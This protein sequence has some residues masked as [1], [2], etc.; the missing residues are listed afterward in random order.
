MYTMH[1]PDGPRTLVQVA[2]AGLLLSI[3]S[4]PAVAQQ[5]AVPI[6]V[7]SAPVATTMEPIHFPAEVQ[8]LAG[9]RL[10]VNAT[11]D[12]RLLVFDRSLKTATVLADTNG[13]VAVYPRFSRLI[14]YLGD[15][16]L[17]F[18]AATR[19]LILVGEEG[20]LG[21]VIALPKAQDANN[22]TNNMPV[23]VD[24][25]GRLIYAGRRPFRFP[26]SCRVIDGRATRDSLPAP[27][28][29]SVTI[30][31]ADFDTRSVDTIGRARVSVSGVTFP[32]MVTDANCRVIS[33]K[34]RID[35]SVPEVDSWTV[36]STGQV[37]IVRGHDYHVD[38]IDAS[39]TQRSTPKL[40]FDLRRYTD[41][42]KQARVDSAR[43]IVDSL[44]ALGGYRLQACGSSFAF[45]TSPPSDQVA[46]PGSPSRGGAGGGGGA[47][48]G[49]GGGRAA[50]GVGT[51]GGG[52][53]PSTRDCQTVTATA[54]YP[55]LDEMPNYLAP[56]REAAARADRDGNVWILPTTSAGAKGGLLYDVVNAKGELAERV[57][58]PANRDIAGF[59]KDGVLFLSHRADDGSISIERV[60][61]V[62]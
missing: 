25:R 24:A 47:V 18:E 28:T 35:P 34:V 14:R 6:R 16:V 55:A 4:A 41:A 13:D 52:A 5:G 11:A 39:G 23:G 21:R 51:T 62:R 9:G 46:G 37:A 29:D 53:L 19:S 50:V 7:V 1:Q 56:V 54:E 58:L 38:W 26:P 45:N 3:L 60:D 57:Q 2:S 17:F 42:D 22:I 8:E 59:G 20:R 48:G 31:R 27:A 33:A 43:R 40:P 44:V 32:A 49:G 12:R 30:L 15:S 10:L 36:T 61:V